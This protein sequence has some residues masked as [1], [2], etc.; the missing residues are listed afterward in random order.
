VR[1]AHP[2]GGAEVGVDVGGVAVMTAPSSEGSCRPESI[3]LVVRSDAKKVHLAS[4]VQSRNPLPTR[5]AE[6]PDL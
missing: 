5:L 1:R 6:N 3:A 4:A 2:A